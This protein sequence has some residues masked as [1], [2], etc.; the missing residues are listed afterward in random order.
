MKG[1]ILLFK[2]GFLVLILLLTLMGCSNP[3]P[4]ANRSVQFY[5]QAI[6]QKVRDELG[7][8]IGEEITADELLTITQ[9]FYLGIE[10]NGEPLSF[11]IQDLAMMPNLDYVSLATVALKNI[12]TLSSLTKL[13]TLALEQCKFDQLPPL[14]KATELKHLLLKASRVNDISGLKGATKLEKLDLNSC[15][16]LSDISVLAGMG[17]LKELVLRHAQHISDISALAQT[18]N[19]ERLDA[20]E[21]GI[22]D[23]SPL[24]GLKKLKELEVMNTPISHAY[25]LGDS[26]AAKQYEALKEALPDCA[27]YWGVTA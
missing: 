25:W 16:N 12:N 2:I 1:K 10:K 6:E 8:E 20:R 26:A 21:A 14:A 9:F 27:I 22:N 5:N 17:S 7:K 3:A 15:F 11:D 24:L 23:V 4:A 18:S 13:N 19:L